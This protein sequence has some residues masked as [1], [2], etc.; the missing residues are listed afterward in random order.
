M[1]AGFGLHV[2]QIKL[3]TC[4][5]LFI[6]PG[7]VEQLFFA[8]LFLNKRTRKSNQTNMSPIFESDNKYGP[9]HELLYLS[10]RREAKAQLILRI[11]ANSS[12]PCALHTITKEER[13]LS[14]L[15]FM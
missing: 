1:L 4:L 9:A 12:E 2:G 10:H 3:F 7:I 5:Y 14:S 15:V 6:F 13:K 11:C 8:H